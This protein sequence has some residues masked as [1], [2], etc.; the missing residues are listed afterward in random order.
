MNQRRLLGFGREQAARGCVLSTTSANSSSRSTCQC[1]EDA[2]RFPPPPAALRIMHL[3]QV[4][5][6]SQPAPYLPQTFHCCLSRQKKKEKHKT[7]EK[8][9][10]QQPTKQQ[11][12][13]ISEAVALRTTQAW[14][15][16]RRAKQMPAPGS[17]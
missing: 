14:T 2:R 15:V 13:K 3:L 9:K 6:A 10:N 11:N 16:L 8:K 7:N 12:P 17:A 1:F 5:S 4:P